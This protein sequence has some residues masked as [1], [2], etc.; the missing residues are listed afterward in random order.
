MRNPNKISGKRVG[1]GQV[2]Q[3]NG[4]SWD[5]V[6]Y[7]GQLGQGEGGS[8]DLSGTSGTRRSSWDKWDK[9]KGSVQRE[10]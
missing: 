9:D 7:V 4:T 2:V 6:E 10:G 1:K 8:S 3:P 5:K